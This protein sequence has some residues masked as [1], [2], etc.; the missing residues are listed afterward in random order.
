[1]RPIVVAVDFSNTSV[2]AVEYAVSIANTLNSDVYMVWVDKIGIQE[3]IYPE[4]T[5]ESRTEI[6]KKFEDLIRHY[7]P[8]LSKGLTL[9]Y[10]LRKGKIYREVDTFAQSVRAG[11]IITGTHG[12]SGFEEYWLGSN[13]YKIVSFTSLPVITL[14]HDFPVSG[15]VRKI[16]MLMDGSNET[17]QKVP[18]TAKIAEIFGAE[19]LM[20]TIHGNNLKSIQRIAE[21]YTRMAS[22][23]FQEHDI[24]YSEESI[25]ATNLIKTAVDYA[26]NHQVDLISVMT[27]QETPVNI[28]IGAQVQQL[29]SQS[30]IPIMS[31]TPGDKFKLEPL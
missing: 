28:Y 15:S 20:L 24:P 8:G 19:I 14:R 31:I 22:A 7:R 26:V 16:L 18:F 29:I 25:V 21:K 17:I 6:K 1:M 12:I 3:T 11:M 5:S 27:E 9:D 30:P 13:A 23:F 10:K 2:H 4:S